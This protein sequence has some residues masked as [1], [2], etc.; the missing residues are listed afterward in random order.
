ML[1]NIIFL[2]NDDKTTY[3]DSKDTVIV[4]DD[5]HVLLEY[6]KKGYAVVFYTKEDR[7]ID[8]AKYIIEEIESAT[9]EYCNHVYCRE[10]G[11]PYTILETERTIVR[12]ITVADVKNL[13]ALY[14]EETLR[15]N[16]PLYSYE[17]ECEF[18]R[19]YIDKMYGLYG[20][21][22]WVVIDKATNRLIGR[23]GISIREY[24]GDFENELGYIF[25][26]DFRKKGYATEACQGIVRYAREALDMDK[27]MI[28]THP[29]NIASIR[30]AKKLG[31]HFK[32]QDATKYIME[33]N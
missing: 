33:L 20:Y 30:L 19:E 16:E 18:T 7:Y 4:T 14:D 27:I 29:D 17:K 12:E 11:I 21:G 6:T 26:K 24:D 1:K 22:L 13:Y 3:F 23:A 9:F 31:F 2:L 32:C 10:K 5:E 25:H 28:L 8:G 15:F